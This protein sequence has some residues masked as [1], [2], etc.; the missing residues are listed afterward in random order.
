MSAASDYLE[1]E[2]LDHVL[3]KGTRNFT[4]P[5]VLAVA[6]FTS[7]PTDSG[8]GT[9]VADA[10]GY[11]RKAVTFAAASGGSAAT[12]GDL[13]FG[14]ASGGNFGTIAG[15]GI[16]DNAGYG[17]GNLLIFTTLATP[18]TVSDGD[19]FVISAGNL[20]VSLA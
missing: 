18:K 1:L 14:P 5:P 6:L 8:G 16:F 15:I 13:T 9:E 11:T 2:V 3:G 10:N 4:S 17:A 19:T 20:T 12:S 7:M